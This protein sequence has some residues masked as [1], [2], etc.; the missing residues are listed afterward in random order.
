MKLLKSSFEQLTKYF[1]KDFIESRHKSD[2][3]LHDSIPFL[4]KD[5]HV[6]GGLLHRADIGVWSKKDVLQL[7]LALVDSLNGESFLPTGLASGEIHNGRI[8]LG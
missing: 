7:S 1:I 2:L 4:V 3:S 8:H 5:V 6:L